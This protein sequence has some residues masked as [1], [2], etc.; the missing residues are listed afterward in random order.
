MGRRRGRRGRRS[1][2]EERGGLRR[3][4]VSSCM[5]SAVCD[6]YCNC[7]VMQLHLFTC[8]PNI[9]VLPVSI[10]NH[11][12]CWYVCVLPLQGCTIYKQGD[13]VFIGKLLKGCDAELSGESCRQERAPLSA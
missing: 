11:H 3:L 2:E 6:V 5:V 7:D 9:I 4:V 1:G 8:V 10:S 12:L 13:A